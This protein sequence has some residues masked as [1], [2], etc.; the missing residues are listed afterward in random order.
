MNDVETFLNR[1]HDYPDV[2]T[3]FTSGCCYWF[4]VILMLRFSE[5]LPQ[6]MYD[7][8]ANHFGVQIN[9]RVYDITGNVTDQYS[10]GKW[11]DIDD[12]LWKSRI[13]R[14]TVMF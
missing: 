7:S 2:D 8:V 6:L 4:A 13:I 12:E 5:S 1:F 10:W 3:T 9:G 14:D 11:S